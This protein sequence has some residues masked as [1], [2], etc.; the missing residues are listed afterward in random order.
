WG[1]G[2][3]SQA[4]EDAIVTA[5]NGGVT[6]VAA[7]GNASND[8]DA[9]PT[10]PAS[11][12]I[13]N[14]LT[15][16]ATTD[17]DGMAGFSNFGDTS[18]HVASPG[19]SILSTLPNDSFGYSSGTSMSA[20]FVAGLSALMIREKGDINGYQVK[21]IIH[22]YS[23]VVNGLNGKVSSDSRINA[24]NAIEF[25]QNNNIDDYQPDFVNR[26]LASA[27]AAGGGCG[28]VGKVLKK[29]KS[30]QGDGKPP[31]GNMTLLFV[32]LFAPIFF[33]N[34][35]KYRHQKMLD[36]RRQHPRYK[37]DSEVS[38]D[39][40]GRKLVGQVSSISLGGARIDTEAMLENGGIVTLSIES[41]DGAQ[42]VQVEGRVVWSEEKKAYG[43]KF[44]AAKDEAL[45]ALGGS[46]KKLNKI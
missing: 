15:I 17:S 43:V 5:Y 23:F 34:F 39:V 40:G 7:A 6:F 24:L 1:G 13:P 9:A 2:S 26:D 4:L 8:N 31:W 46:T 12:T 28:L 44:T 18:V 41:P 33:M 29:H 22:D 14:V 35:L 3:Y 30:G 37:I 21:G 25:V 27:G 32:V 45:S 10:Y 19:V 20:P 16:A 36:N 11:Y 42:Q 38:I